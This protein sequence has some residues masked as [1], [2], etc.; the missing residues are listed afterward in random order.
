MA[1]HAASRSAPLGNYDDEGR[2]LIGFD[3]I[4]FVVGASVESEQEA[5]T[6]LE[7]AIPLFG[8]MQLYFIVQR[9]DNFQGMN[10]GWWVV[11]EAYQGE[12]STENLASRPP[13][14]PRRTREERHGQDL[15]SIPVY[16]EMVGGV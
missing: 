13:C 4:R 5:Q 7:D 10:P 11:I 12:P 9:S 3:R 1:P 16:E 14:V 6:M 15:G 8:D 2:R